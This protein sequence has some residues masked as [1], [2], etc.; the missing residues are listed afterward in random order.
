MGP[1]PSPSNTLAIHIITLDFAINITNKIW[2][3][4]KKLKLQNIIINGLKKFDIGIHMARLRVITASI[5]VR[6]SL[7]KSLS[8]SR[9]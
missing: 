9:P 2:E 3:T 4:I 7:A 8:S 5:A 1:S 6:M